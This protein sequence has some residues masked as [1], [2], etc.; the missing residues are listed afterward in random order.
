MVC[1]GGTFVIQGCQKM[2]DEMLPTDELQHVSERETFE[3][4]L[5]YYI[6]FDEPVSYDDIWKMSQKKGISVSQIQYSVIEGNEEKIYSEPYYEIS[7]E[8]FLLQKN[9]GQGMIDDALTEAIRELE[10]QGEKGFEEIKSEIARNERTEISDLKVHSIMLFLQ[11]ERVMKDLQSKF[12]G[13]YEPIIID[14][15]ALKNEHNMVYPTGELPSAN[16]RSLNES[17]WAPSQGQ[18]KVKQLNNSFRYALNFFRFDENN[19]GPLETYEHDFILNASE[20]S[21]FGPGTY[22]DPAQYGNG[23]PILTTWKS[24][25]PGPYLDTRA[26]DPDYQKAYTIGTYWAPNMIEDKWYY[27]IVVTPNTSTQYDNAMMIAQKGRN[28][29]FPIL[30]PFLK[31]NWFGF[32]KSSTANDSFSFCIRFT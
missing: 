17:D 20:G 2:E 15:E 5:S 4:K 1:I 6:T 22:L 25:M 3:D 9:K 11:D 8:E 31:L 7:E 32:G 16:I 28:S 14:Y 21:H 12:E 13:K 19:F 26:F 18:L 10:A 24:N 23:I 29:C 27:T 30:S